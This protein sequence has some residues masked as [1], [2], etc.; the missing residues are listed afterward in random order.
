VDDLLPPSAKLKPSVEGF[1]QR[2]GTFREEKKIRVLADA[3]T[4]MIFELKP[5]LWPPCYVPERS[6]RR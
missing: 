3:C 2:R 6:S 5:T 4:K 1:W